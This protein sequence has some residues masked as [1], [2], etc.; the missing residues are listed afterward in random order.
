[1]TWKQRVAQSLRMFGYDLTRY[2]PG[3]HPVAQL[4]QLMKT[5]DTNLVLDIGA[6]CGQYALD[7]RAN[8]YRGRMIS[9]EPLS[10][11]YEKLSKAASNDP[12]WETMQVALGSAAGKSQINVAGNSTSSSLLGMLPA[13]E[14]AA[15]SSKY[16]STEDIV[17]ETV[18]R[19]LPKLSHS[20]GSIWMKVDTQGFEG[21][22]LKGCLE[23]LEHINCIQL[24][25]S[26][27]PL[28]E[29]S[30]TFETLLRWMLNHDYQLV[31]LQPGFTDQ[32]TGRLLQ[33]DGIFHSVV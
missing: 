31:G 14:D 9:F 21:E 23:S 3:R 4:M 2:Q 6:N 27:M 30:E 8:G 22:V 10:S 28:Y 7:L 33:V 25:M 1:M 15:P 20:D 11:A 19:V 18:D 29:G 5:H 32:R 16:V 26:L 12:H 13:H 24:E 17:V